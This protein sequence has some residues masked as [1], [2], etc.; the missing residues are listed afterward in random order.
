MYIYISQTFAFIL[1]PYLTMT[2]LANRMS[3]VVSGSSKVAPH[4]PFIALT[5]YVLTLQIIY[6]LSLTLTLLQSVMN[7]WC[8]NLG[9]SLTRG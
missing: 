3:D 8:F 7:G 9:L 6:V 2:F 4:T 5:F 1:C